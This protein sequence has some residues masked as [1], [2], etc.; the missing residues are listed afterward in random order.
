MQVAIKQLNSAFIDDQL[1]IHEYE[2][3]AR[4]LLHGL[5]W[6]KRIRYV[7]QLFISI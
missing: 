2:E 7:N 1:S 3:K 4:A 6:Q 5:D